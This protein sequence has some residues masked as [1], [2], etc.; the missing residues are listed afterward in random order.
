MPKIAAPTVKEH[1]DIVF[2]KLLDTTEEILREQGPAALTASSVARGAGI[3]RNSIYRYVRSIDDLRIFVL[4]RYLPQWTEAM[5]EVIDPEAPASEQL[6]A[7]TRQSL[8]MARVTG[9]GWLM[10]VLA[11]GKKRIGGT[12]GAPI[13]ERGTLPESEVILD[14]HK[15]LVGRIA[16]LWA[17]VTPDNAKV[18]A[19]VNA[20]LIDSGMAQIDSGEDADRVIR[21]VSAALRGMMGSGDA[22]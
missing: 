22:E 19:R 17:E 9:H 15:T 1:H 2:A 20:A 6:I 13:V 4:E 18:N 3:A 16:Q 12:P 5:R 14:F 7:M 8:E 10:D 11:G 21:A